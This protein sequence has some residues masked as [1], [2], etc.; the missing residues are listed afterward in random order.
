VALSAGGE[1]VVRIAALGDLHCTTRS[2]G[3]LQGLLNHVAERADVLALCG[4]L[5]DYGL[6]EEARILAH[7]L[8]GLPIP[9]V[10]VL[11]NHDHESDASEEVVRIL[12]KAGVRVL[13]GESCV[14][15]DVGF[16]GTKGFGGGFGRRMLGRWGEDAIK[17]FVQEALDE[18]LKLESALARLRTDRRV[19]LLHYSP[20]RDT[21]EGEPLELY[22]YLGC[23]RLE[24]PLNRYRVD[25][26]FHGHSHYG[27]LEG[28]TTA[29]AP[30]YNV[31]LPLMRR[32]MRAD[33]P[34]RIIE[35]P[36]GGP[37]ERIGGPTAPEAPTA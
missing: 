17:H 18:E 31:A 4:D 26:V 3:T 19:V 21:V 14:I 1:E 8:S 20:V 5:T 7:E 34:V 29:G 37:G 23:S 24:E 32:R 16:A 36:R 10:A 30:V 12:A 9:V 35:L 15:E 11:G 27:S 22:P 6:P 28:R 13:Q 25:V 33:L 2:T